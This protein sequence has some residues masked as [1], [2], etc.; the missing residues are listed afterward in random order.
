MLPSGEPRPGPLGGVWWG[1]QAA[2][3]GDQSLKLEATSAEVTGELGMGV[4]EVPEER[5]L[6]RIGKRPGRRRRGGQAAGEA[7]RGETQC[8]GMG[9]GG[10][11]VWVEV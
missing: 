8:D 2:L 4:D 10:S 3:G 6:P 1:N 11:G 9:E 5:G 7:L